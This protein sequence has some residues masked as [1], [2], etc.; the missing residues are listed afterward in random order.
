MDSYQAS[1]GNRSD[2]VM[3]AKYLNDPPTITGKLLSL[4]SDETT[5]VVIMEH[6]INAKKFL[7]TWQ[8]SWGNENRSI[9]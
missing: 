4:P 1:I 5:E 9:S 6:K 3:L 8:T 2:P 7:N